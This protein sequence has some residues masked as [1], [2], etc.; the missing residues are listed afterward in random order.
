ML[1]LQHIRENKYVILEGLKKRNFHSP[2]KIDQILELDQERRAQQ[3]NL[4]QHLA[5]ANNL[6]K[7]IGMLF[8]KGEVAK[9]NELKKET[10]SLKELTKKI[11]K[12]LQNTTVS[13]NE[14]RIQ[15]PNVPHDSVP[16]GSGEEDNEEIFQSGNIPN[17]GNEPLAHWD[18]A[19]KYDLIDF[20][21][22]TKIT[23]AGFPVYKGKGARLQRG[24]VNYLLDKNTQ[25]GYLEMQVPHLVNEASGF[26]T[27]QLPDKEGQMYQVQNDDLY[28]IPTA[29]VPLTNLYRDALLDQKD[30]P[31]CLTGYTPCFRRE[32]GSYG[33]HVRG[34]NRLHQFDKVEIVRIEEP[35]NAMNALNGMVEHV[36]VILEDLKL[37][38]RILRLC[39]GD[40]GFTSALTYDFEIYSAAQKRWLEISSVSTF[41]SF[42]AERLQLRYKTKEGIKQSVHT[43]NGSSLALPR[44]VAGMLENCQTDD[45][46]LI[47]KALVPYTGFDKIN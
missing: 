32:A 16:Q 35:Q 27:G 15:I 43:L 20:D 41:N 18:L 28:L 39:G 17:L 26:G 42:Q 21:L 40:L 9:A 7:E 22:G 2:E 10:T 45:G 14:L 24:L 46:I 8:K 11:Q 4:D 5:Q 13:L 12:K 44:V 1:A 33:A 30:L 3:A 31:I 36:K 34:L 19:Q 6:A 47:P 25:S 38:Y 23:G 29:E 37:P